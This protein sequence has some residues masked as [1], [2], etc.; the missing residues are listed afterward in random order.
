LNC[1]INAYPLTNRYFWRKDGNFINQ[2]M[3][4]DIRN[5][6]LS[7]YILISQL[8][9]KVKFVISSQTNFLKF[10]FLNFK[11]NYQKDYDEADQGLYECSAENDMRVSKIVYNLRGMLILSV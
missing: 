2:D 1:T 4:H 10:I 11:F 9:I 8:V 3:K 6:R 7:E 5:V